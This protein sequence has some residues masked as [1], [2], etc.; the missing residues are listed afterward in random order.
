MIYSL[1]GKYIHGE[2]GFV[3]IECSGVGFRVQTS[4]NTKK[5]LKDGKEVTLFTHMNVREDSME[6]FGFSTSF[7]LDTFKQLISINGVGPKAAI[8][9]L[10]SL[11]SEQLALCVANGDYKTITI[12]QGV[13]PKLAQ[14]IVL[15]LKD[16]FKNMLSEAQTVAKGSVIPQDNK[17]SQ[18]I[19]ALAVLGYSAA[20]VTPVLSKLDS[21]LSVEALIRETMKAMKK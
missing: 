11:T 21:G 5:D 13:G 9:I 16:K 7:E 18:A 3:V 20:E 12:A 10:S 15:E 4:L 2:T 6:L 14:R 8:S 19:S 17:I 1:R